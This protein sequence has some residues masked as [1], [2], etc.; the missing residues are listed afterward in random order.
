M[1]GCRKGTVGKAPGPVSLQSTNIGSHT[2]DGKA[3]REAGLLAS[4][5]LGHPLGWLAEERNKLESMRNY[6]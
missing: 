6:M 2:W 5:K 4:G 3:L 1:L